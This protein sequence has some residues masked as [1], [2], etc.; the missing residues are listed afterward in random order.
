MIERLENKLAAYH[1]KKYAL[2]TNSG[3]NALLSMYVGAN[4]QEND[5]VLC[6]VYTFYATVTPLLFTGAVPIFIDIDNEGNLDPK[7]LARKLTPKTKAI[8][9]THM[10]GLPANMEEI[11]NFAKENK[12]MLFEDGSHAHGSEYKGQKIGTFGDAA[13]FSLQGQKTLTGGEGGFLLTD[14]EEIYYRA[15]L[16]GHYNKRCIK[17]IPSFHSFHK[18]AV[19]GMGLKF[20]IHPLAAAIAEE[21]F[22]HLDKIISERTNY[23]NFMLKELSNLKG[24]HLPYTTLSNKKSSWYGLIFILKASEL[25]N[26]TP[27]AFYRMLQDEGCSEL[28]RPSSTCPLNLHPLFQSPY[29]LF[30][31]YEGKISYKRGDFPKAEAYHTYSFKLPV[32]HDPKD[33]E[34]VK[35]YMRAIRKV[36]TQCQ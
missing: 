10:W 16:L 22:E 32:W 25:N 11:V 18:Y 13:A 31:S 19:T 14:N 21:Q 33:I 9:I 29:E 3:T 17:E 12:L 30:P 2:L 4:L 27:D 7:E 36:V 24:I 8:V 15:L 6:P 35:L 23:A 5:E 20:R 26:V 28:D 1:K 34:I